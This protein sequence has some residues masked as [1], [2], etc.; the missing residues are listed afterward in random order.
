MKVYKV[1]GRFASFGQGIVLNLTPEQASIRDMS[2][3]KIRGSKN[4]YV[5]NERVVFKKGE[6]VIV[7]NGEVSK[8]H[9][10]NLSELNDKKSNPPK[11]NKTKSKPKKKTTSKKEKAK[12]EEEDK[13]EENSEEEETSNENLNPQETENPPLEETEEDKNNPE[14]ENK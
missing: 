14:E 12:I 10:E 5:V 9:L 4:H 7:V 1:K 13:K 11:N 8:K 3:S 2:I 6:K